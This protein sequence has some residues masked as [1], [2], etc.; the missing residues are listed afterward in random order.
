[1]WSNLRKSLVISS[2]ADGRC[3]SMWE[4]SKSNALCAEVQNVGTWQVP[5]SKSS[6]SGFF[7]ADCQ[8]LGDLTAFVAYPT[9]KFAACTLDSDMLVFLF[10]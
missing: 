5:L 9:R 2:V 7:L 10:A 8:G 4:E 6:G 3:C 1:M